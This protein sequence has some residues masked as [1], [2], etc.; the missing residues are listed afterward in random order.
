M[1]EVRTLEAGPGVGADDRDR[2]VRAAAEALSGGAILAHPTETVYG[3]GALSPELDAEIARVKGR[4]DDRPLLRIG[5]DAETVRRRHPGLSWGEAAERL[6]SAFWPG[7][8]T[9]VL[10]DGSP[11]GQ[12]VRVEGHPLTR[13]VLEILEETMSSTSLNPSG[14]RPAATPGEV[15]EDLRNLPEPR[16]PVAWL[17]AG[18][19]AGG[20]PSTLVSLR[21]E[22]PRLL[23]EGAIG[24]DRVERALGREMARG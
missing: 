8:L 15:R 1:R 19:L 2:A 21:G 24:R 23:R 9:L 4:P 14:E 6:A 3:L 16:A 7:P 18:S 5:P 11:H 12:G 17:D 20:P 22:P 13:R 10:D